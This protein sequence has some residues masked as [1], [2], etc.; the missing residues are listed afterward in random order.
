M[1]DRDC[2]YLKSCDLADV[3]P[4]MY[5]R[6]CQWDLMD[7]PGCSRKSSP[8]GMGLNLCHHQV[9]NRY[10]SPS[11]SLYTATMYKKKAGTRLPKL[12]SRGKRMV[13]FLPRKGQHLTLRHSLKPAFNL[14]KP[15]KDSWQRK[16]LA[17][18]RSMHK[19]F[20]YFPRVTKQHSMLGMSCAMLRRRCMNWPRV[21]KNVL[22]SRLCYR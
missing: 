14:L 17:N 6:I 9:Q 4:C 13:V 18:L 8:S 1:F 7:I 22:W 16:A 3:G 15:S 20:L 21:R 5:S 10:Q 2:S 11:G 19:R 12:K